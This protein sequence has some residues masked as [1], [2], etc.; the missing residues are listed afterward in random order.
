M[1][2]VQH[3]NLQLIVSL[4]LGRNGSIFTKLAENWESMVWYFLLDQKFSLFFSSYSISIVIVIAFSLPLWT[5]VDSAGGNNELKYLC[6]ISFGSI[7]YKLPHFLISGNAGKEEHLWVIIS[8]FEIVLL[9]RYPLRD[10]QRYLMCVSCAFV[11][12]SPQNHLSL[13]VMSS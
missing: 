8:T 9:N 3:P 2:Y 10:N 13:Y 6:W 4:I 11:F 1:F 12:T 7:L 5:Q